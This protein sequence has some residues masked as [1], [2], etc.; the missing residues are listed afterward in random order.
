MRRTFK[1]TPRE[2]EA[3]AHAESGL[4]NNEVAGRMGVKPTT[5]S[6]LLSSARDKKRSDSFTPGMQRSHAPSV[7]R[8]THGRSYARRAFTGIA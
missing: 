6:A 5:V 8:A 7:R 3:L 2:S 1:P 4:D